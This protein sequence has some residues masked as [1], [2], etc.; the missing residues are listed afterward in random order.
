MNVMLLGHQLKDR[1]ETKTELLRTFILDGDRHFFT[2]YSF[3]TLIHFK[4]C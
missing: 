2:N 1:D 4:F 3:K